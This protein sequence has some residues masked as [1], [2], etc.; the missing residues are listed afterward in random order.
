MAFLS[1][2]HTHSRYSDGINTIEEIVKMAISKGFISL[3]MSEHA[4]APYDL[5]CC[6]KQSDVPKYMDEM[7]SLKEKYAG[8]IELYTGLEVDSYSPVD[9]KGLD[10]TLGAVHY[11]RDEIDGNYH[12][13]DYLPQHFESALEKLAGGDIKKLMQVYYRQVVDFAAEY[14]PDIIAHVDLILKLNGDSRYMDEQS[15]WYKKLTAKVAEE[16]ATTG[17]IVEVNTGA[18]ARG[19]RTHP[20]PMEAFLQQL[21]DLNIPLTLNSD[22]HSAENIDCAFDSAITMLK[23]AGCGSLKQMRGGVFIDVEI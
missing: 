2:M 5:E 3:G 10:F 11:L 15:A 12:T 22:A 9:R 16:I 6:I 20:Y 7:R 13:I 19:Y 23:A 14:K 4:Y 17:C 21:L 18:I 1:N 8:E